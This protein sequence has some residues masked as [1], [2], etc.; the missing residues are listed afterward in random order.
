MRKVL[1]ASSLIAALVSPL[2]TGCANAPAVESQIVS[3]VINL[4]TTGCKFVP[5]A[6]AIVA[7]VAAGDPLLAGASSIANYIC[8]QIKAGAATISPA[9]MV[10]HSMSGG[11]KKTHALLVNGAP[12]VIDGV[13]VT[14]HFQK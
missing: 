9:V 12:L 13:T 10:I 11:I 6:E 2:A 8:A 3:T 14:G 1:I 5:D 7:I 4:C